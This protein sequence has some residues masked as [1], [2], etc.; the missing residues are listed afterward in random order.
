[1]FGKNDISAFVERYKATLTHGNLEAVA[2]DCAGHFA[3]C[4]GTEVVWIGKADRPETKANLIIASPDV[5]LQ[6]SSENQVVFQA[7]NSKGL[8]ADL[9]N[10]LIVP[11]PTAGIH[12]TAVVHPEASIDPSASIGPYC[13]IGH[14]SVGASTVMDGH[15]FVHDGSQIGNHVRI[16]A[17]VTIGAQ[18][19][20]LT[21]N[22][23]GNW[24][25]FPQMGKVILKD[26][27]SVGA[28]T[29]I[30]RGALEDTIVETFTHIGLS[31]AIAHNTRIGANTLILA[32]TVICG[33]CRI[34]SDV[35]IAPG[36]S[37]INK[38]HIGDG[39]VVGLGS[40]VVKDVPAGVTVVG[41]PA[42]RI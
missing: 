11:K 3:Q 2:F 1:M 42:S 39:A 25:P 8:F 17:N 26:H 31:C 24:I 12:V 21:K 37:I 22:D 19:S 13:V 30:A 36:S 41:N 28:N 40:N 38:C 7:E 23:E 9:V 5:Q 10:A 4:Q 16:G 32:N 18:G 33:S 15:V 27:V 6:N 14:C 29:Y 35:W 34:G 20:G